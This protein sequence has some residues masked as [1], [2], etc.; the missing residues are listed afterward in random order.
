MSSTA[1]RRRVGTVTRPETT[2]R[3]IYLDHQATTPCDPRVVAAMLPYFSEQ[4]GNPA[5]TT[6][7]WGLD[8]ALAVQAARE[9]IARLV[10]PSAPDP[11]EIIFT[12]GAT[13]TLNLAIKGLAEDRPERRRIVVSAFEHRAVLDT[14]AHLAKRGFETVLVPVSPDGFVAPDDVTRALDGGPGGDALLVAVMAAQNEIGTLQPVA[15]IGALCAARGVPFLVDAVQAIGKTPIDLHAVGATL[16]ALSAHKVYGP[17]GVGALW[18]RRRP[19]LGLVA[20]LDGGG[21]ERGYRSGTLNVPGIVGFGVAAELARS[22]GA[23][24][25]VRL[26]DLR[27]RLW[28]ALQEGFPEVVLNG[29]WAPRLAGNLHVALPGVEGA[30]LMRALPELGLAAGSACTSRDL[31]GSHVLAAIGASDARR[32]GSLRIGIGRWTSTDDVVYAGTRIAEMARRLRHTNVHH[33]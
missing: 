19:P 17:K 23:A 5:S 13:E 27:T 22:E 8:A 12:S 25:A 7:R 9:S 16:A 31:K 24:E 3:P 1:M 11:R 4:F 15:E 32:F 29:A 30:A 20:Q 18:I 6:H 14:C 21:H 33:S 10:A 28:E 26:L 2:G